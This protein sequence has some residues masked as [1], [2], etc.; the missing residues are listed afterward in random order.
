MVAFG[1]FHLALAAEATFTKSANPT[2]TVSGFVTAFAVE[3]R[4]FE[5]AGVAGAFAVFK[6]A[7]TVQLAVFKGATQLIAALISG[8]TEALWLA[9]A[10]AACKAAAVGAL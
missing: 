1:I 9:L 6:R 4:V 7:F 5:A 8:G 10:K 3:H 2:I